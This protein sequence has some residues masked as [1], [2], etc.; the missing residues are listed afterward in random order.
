MHQNA[1]PRIAVVGLGYVGLPLA[2]ALAR[3]FPVVAYDIDKSRIAELKR[4]HDR[5]REIAEAEGARVVQHPDV[6]PRYGSFRGKGWI[7]RNGETLSLEQMEMT[8]EFNPSNPLL[9]E[10]VQLRATDERG[11]TIVV[12]GAVLSICPTK[13]P[14]RDG[15]TFINEGLAR[16]ETEGRVGYG[17]SEHWHAVPR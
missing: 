1:P 9:H 8:T 11:G 13:V 2:V 6:L 4:G 15:V 16:F 3:S 12:N 10:R 17:I 7:Q 14:R 5:T